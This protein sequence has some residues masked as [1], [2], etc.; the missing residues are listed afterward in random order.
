MSVL[1]HRDLVMHPKVGNGQ[2]R[3]LSVHAA[4]ALVSVQ[5]GWARWDGQ[6]VGGQASREDGVVWGVVTGLPF[7]RPE[8]ELRWGKDP[9]TRSLTGPTRIRVSILR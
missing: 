7:W 9:N 2:C 3:G 8:K 1:I 6:K 5:W 4:W